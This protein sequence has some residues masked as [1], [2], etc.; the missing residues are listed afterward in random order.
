MTDCV[1]TGEREWTEAHWAY[2]GAAPVRVRGGAGQAAVASPSYIFRRQFRLKYKCC[3]GANTRF[4]WVDGKD[5]PWDQLE[6]GKCIEAEGSKDVDPHPQ[7]PSE[8]GE[9]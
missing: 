1:S 7:D 2:R 8:L 9:A 3:E 4:V 6:P 5:I